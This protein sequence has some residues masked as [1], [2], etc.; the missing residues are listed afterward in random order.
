MGKMAAEPKGAAATVPP[1]LIFVL[2]P[3]PP[4][5]TIG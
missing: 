1:D 3:S 2:S 5:G 4:H